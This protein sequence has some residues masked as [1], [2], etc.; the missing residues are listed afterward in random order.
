[1]DYL[2]YQ[3]HPL[4]TPK[5]IYSVTYTKMYLVLLLSSLEI[6]GVIIIIM[7]MIFRGSSVVSTT[8]RS[9]EFDS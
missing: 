1:M 3:R 6:C 9:P 2:W 8:V 5:T 7:L 4:D